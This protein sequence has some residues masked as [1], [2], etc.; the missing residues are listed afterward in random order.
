MDTHV[1]PLGGANQGEDG[2]TEDQGGVR[3]IG[4]QDGAT[5]LENQ[6]DAAGPE[7]KGGVEKVC[8]PGW[9]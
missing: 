9:S 5:E 7:G 2:E 8:R 1:G 3:K 6:A 4:H